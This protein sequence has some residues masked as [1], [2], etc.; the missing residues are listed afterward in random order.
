[1]KYGFLNLFKSNRNKVILITVLVAGSIFGLIKIFKKD[2]YAYATIINSSSYA[3]S[4]VRVKFC[5]QCA[6]VKELKS[7]GDQV[8]V[9]FFNKKS[10]KPCFFTVNATLIDKKGKTKEISED[11]G[12]IPSN[13]NFYSR[14]RFLDDDIILEPAKKPETHK[15]Q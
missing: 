4:D 13:K 6:K 9:S 7:P 10:P 11:L 8:A 14:L 5:G 2:A 12:I 3:I 15:P 1:M